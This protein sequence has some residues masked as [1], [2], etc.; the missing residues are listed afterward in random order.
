MNTPQKK[1]RPPAPLAGNSIARDMASSVQSARPP[2]V[3]PAARPA[4][5]AVLLFA[6]IAAVATGAFFFWKK[7]PPKTVNQAPVMVARRIPTAGSAGSG[8]TV[9]DVPAPVGLDA[10]VSNPDVSAQISARVRVAVD[11]R[12]GG[13]FGKLNLD[14]TQTESLKD[15]LTRKATVA[16]DL[17]AAA[18]GQGVNPRDNPEQFQQLVSQ[19]QAQVDTSITALLG[20]A[21]YQIYTAYSGTLPQHAVID[22]LSQQL[23]GGRSPLAGSQ[24]EMLLPILTETAGPPPATDPMMLMMG[25][26]LMSPPTQ[27]TDET[28]QRAQSILTPEQLQVLR[29][30]Q[31]QQQSGPAPAGG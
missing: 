14:S 2:P 30:I 4:M 19:A 16:T 9:A 29:Q 15:L 5:P 17:L 23:G 18:T 11:S 10:F 12:Y 3:I 24:A 7:S 1:N 6:V 8:S 27:I 28:I 21:G 31:T 25:G 26:T 20:D 13:L 22:Q